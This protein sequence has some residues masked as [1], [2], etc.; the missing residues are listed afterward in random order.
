M[1]TAVTDNDYECP[2]KIAARQATIIEPYR[3]LFGFEVPSDKQ[4]WTMCGRSAEDDG[5]FK[6]KSELGQTLEAGLIKPNQFHGVERKKD[7]FKLNQAC[8]NDVNWYCGDFF[9]VMEE[10]KTKGRFSPAIVN[11]D[12]ITMPETSMPYIANIMDLLSRGNAPVMFVVNLVLDSRFRD[13]QTTDMAISSLQEHRQYKSAMR[14]KDWNLYKNGEYLYKG[15]GE[16]SKTIMGT[17]V[18]YFR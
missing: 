2:K 13:M 4:Y 16:K 7:W 6:I 3:E 17:L 9:S 8:R 18:F 11:A 5:T 15:S 12:L 10:N 1:K 14:K